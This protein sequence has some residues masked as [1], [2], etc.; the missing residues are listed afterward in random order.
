[1]NL[2]GNKMSFIYL[3]MLCKQ[4]KRI[5]K[6][7]KRLCKQ[8]KKLGKQNKMFGKQKKRLCKQNKKLGKQKKKPCKQKKRLF[9]YLIMPFYLFFLYQ[10][11]ADSEL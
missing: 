8:K 1:M 9:I 4:K 10:K 11:I 2:Q 3:I 5:G 7:N 6:Q